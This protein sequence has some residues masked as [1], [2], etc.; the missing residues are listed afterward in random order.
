MILPD[1]HD[2]QPKAEVDPV[3]GAGIS[4][5]PQATLQ[6]D[7]ITVGKDDP[8]SGRSSSLLGS[9]HPVERQATPPPRSPYPI[10][11][12]GIRGPG[13]PT[14]PGHADDLDGGEVGILLLPLFLTPLVSYP[15]VSLPLDADGPRAI[16]AGGDVTLSEVVL[17]VP[18]AGDASPRTDAGMPGT[19]SAVALGDARCVSTSPLPGIGM[20]SS[21]PGRIQ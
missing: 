4:C 19:G 17:L 21:H 12:T 18:S 9:A 3:D 6:L 2:E 15:L 1:R 14:F 20:T 7:Q 8:Q 16:F 10:G 11:S 5:D 13:A